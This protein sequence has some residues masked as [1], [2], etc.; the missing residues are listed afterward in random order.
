[1]PDN[2]RACQRHYDNMLPP[3]DEPDEDLEDDDEED[4]DETST[5]LPEPV[6]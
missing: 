1:M 6:T 3:D 5:D 2:F 4:D